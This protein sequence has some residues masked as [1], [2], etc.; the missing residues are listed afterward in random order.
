[1]SEIYSFILINNNNIEHIYIFIGKQVVKENDNLG[2]NGLNIVSNQIWNMIDTLNIP[3]TLIRAKIYKDDTVL[4][5][6]EKLVKYSPINV[7]LPEIYLFSFVQKKV[8]LNNI[9]GELT[10]N[11][12]LPLTHERLNNFLKNIEL[13]NK[14]V[15]II[16]EKKANYSYNDLQN[17]NINFEESIVMKQS[18]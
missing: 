6:K 1:M 16:R 4:R 7:S 17:L 18:L 13:N 2:P 12:Y 14:N 11:E 15:E 8:H 10:Q 3:Y 9:Y 5:I